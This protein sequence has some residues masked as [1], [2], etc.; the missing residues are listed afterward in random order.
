[1]RVGLMVR[2]SSQER[3]EAGST[4]TQRQYLE[5]YCFLR[6]WTVVE[7]YV[8]EGVSG[9]TPL[10]ERPDGSRMLRDIKRGVLDAILVYKL[11]RFGR[12]IR[13]VYDGIAALEEAK[14]GF[15]SATESIDTTTPMGRMLLGL[16]A[17]FAAWERDLIK[18]RSYEGRKRSIR[19]GGWNGG[20]PAVGY[21]PDENGRLQID[22]APIES[23]GCSERDIILMIWTWATAEECSLLGISQ[24][25]ADR[26]IPCPYYLNYPRHAR[27]KPPRLT[28]WSFGTLY[29]ILCNPLYKGVY[30]WGR[31]SRRGAPSY[32]TEVPAV[33]DPYTWQRA[34]ELM[35][36]RQKGSRRNS[37]RLYLLGGGLMKCQCGFTFCGGGAGARSTPW[38]RCTHQLTDHRRRTGTTCSAPRL[39]A[40]VVEDRIW[41]DIVE[42]CN[43]PQE[44]L[45]RMTERL[46]QDRENV[47]EI[48]AGLDRSLSLLRGIEESKKRAR[49][50]LVRGKITEPDF[51]EILRDL[52]D[53][54]VGILAMR[55]ASERRLLSIRVGERG[56]TTAREVLVEMRHIASTAK[57]PE[58]KLDLIR[59]AVLSVRVQ[60]VESGG[61]WEVVPTYIFGEIG[62]SSSG[63]CRTNIPTIV[64]PFRVAA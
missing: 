62:L 1:M 17:V 54:E 30:Q 39:R 52:A 24:R 25:L 22:D 10:H 51:D 63:R 27:G 31:E 64:R 47:D 44:A 5:Q 3:A 36:S 16:L 9:T 38:Y 23:L 45:Q 13:V 32:E 37:K 60:E 11:D 15:I 14:V 40:D 35:T 28:V 26:G 46:N 55:D 50:L 19:E 20:I 33:V 12:S 2:V 43:H 58:D 4:E 21:L 53:E 42:F 6:K 8:D 29:N 59:K 56:L 61:G 48:Q 49:A 7:C 41:A 34:R 18:E 57:R